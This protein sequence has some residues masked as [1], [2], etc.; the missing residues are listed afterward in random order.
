VKEEINIKFVVASLQIITQSKSCSKSLIRI[1]F[2]AFL[3]FH[4]LIF[5]SEHIMRLSEQFS[6]AQAAIKS[7]CWV[8]GGYLKARTSFIK[9]V[10]GMIFRISHCSQR[11][12]PKLNFVLSIK[13]QLNIVKPS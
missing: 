8:T 1:L 4:W 6:D 5:S 11:S 10:T 2:P 12:K 13:K 7:I 9:R 3:R